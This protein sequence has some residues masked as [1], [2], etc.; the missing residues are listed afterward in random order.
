M[1]ALNV[2]ASTIKN[3]DVNG[4]VGGY[5]VLANGSDA[6]NQNLGKAGG[7]IGEM[8]GT[9]IKNSDANLF[10]YIIGRE[11]AGGY[12]G[13]MEPGNV[14]SVLKDGNILDGLLN[15]TDS[16]ANLVQSFI[17]II[18]DSQTSSVP[19]GGAVRADGLTSTQCV[20]GL[21]GGYVGYNHGGRILGYA[22]KNGGKECAAIRIRSV[23][24]GEF[25]GGFTGLMETADLAD[26]GNLNLLFGLLSTSNVL[27]LLGAVY[28]TET[29]T[30]VYGPLRKVNMDTWN[31]W[32][33]AVGSNGVYGDQ[34]PN[35]TVGSEQALQD[36]IKKYAY[37][38]N[39]KAGRTSV[40]TQAMEAGAAGGYVGRMKAGV[41]TNAHAWDAKNIT[42]YTSAGGFAGEMKT[43]GAA[44]VGAVSLIG[45][46]ITGSISAVQTFR[47]GNKKF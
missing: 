7:F 6:N 16:L 32:A 29:N 12:A 3:S 15:V 40:G 37:G 31:K 36:A 43:G 33:E 8:S 22:A 5:S 27:S 45:L 46:P 41:V 38:Y 28:P 2:V 10:A 30:A 17:P 19:C 35:T 25:S 4:C 18:E 11:A 24:G 26:T 14:A 9:I 20:R 39:V 13:I 47:S 34:F 42:A 1:E 44:E 21:A 23:Y